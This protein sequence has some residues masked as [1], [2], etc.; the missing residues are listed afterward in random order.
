MAKRKSKKPLKPDYLGD[1]KGSENSYIEK[2][3]PLQSLAQTSLTLPE[4]KILDIYLGRINSHEVDKRTVRFERGDLER[5]L[6]VTQIKMPDLEKR[7]NN[8]FQTIT[9]KDPDKPKGFTK[10]SLFTK[11]VAVADESDLWQVDLTCSEEAREYIFNIDNIGYLRYRLQNVVSLTSRYS[12]ILFLYLLDNRFRKS[13]EISVPELRSLLNCTA[14]RYQKTFKFFN[15]EILKKAHKELTEKTDLCF[16]YKP[17]RRGQRVGSV[18]FTIETIADELANSS[19][20]LPEQLSIIDFEDDSEIDYGGELADLLGSAAC[21]DEF[22]PEQIRVLQDLVVKAV[23]NGDNMD[24]CNYLIHQVHKLN[25]YDKDRKTVK[26]R[27]T[28]L[29]RMIEKEITT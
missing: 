26:N 21:D 8:L 9:I 28:Y 25:L 29:R 17:I 27:F 2:A 13:W 1:W 23:P 15:S 4:F 6:G 16:S 14:E 5:A 10:F 20:R 3:R 19:D 7:I 11:A 22:S 12:Y 24:R 18:R